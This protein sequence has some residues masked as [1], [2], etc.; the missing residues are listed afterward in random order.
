MNHRLAF[1]LALAFSSSGALLGCAA[2]QDDSQ[3]SGGAGASGGGGGAST[4]VGPSTGGGSG[5]GGAGGV[6]GAGGS[7]GGLSG[8]VELCVLN[9]GEPYGTCEQPEELDFGVVSSG[10][11]EKRLFRVDNQTY[12]DLL[13]KSTSIASNAFAVEAVRFEEDPGSPGSYLRVQEALPI[14]RTSDKS[15]WFEVTYT[16]LGNAGPLPSIDVVVK[17]NLGADPIADISVPVVGEESGC[18]VGTGAC[19]ADPANGCETNTQTSNDHCGGCNIP[20]DPVNGSGQCVNGQCELADCDAYF[21]SCD[22]NPANGCET[23]LLSDVNNCGGCGLSC[24]KANTDSFCNGGNC[25]IIGCQNNHADCNLSAADGCE[26]NLANDMSHCGGCNLAC[27]LPNAAESC[28]PSA[29]T[30][31]GVCQLGA[32]NTGFANCNLNPADGCEINTTNDVNNCGQCFQGCNFANASA[33]C[34]NSGCQMGACNANHADCDNSPL[35]GCEVNL[36]TNTNNCGACDNNCVNVIPNSVVSCSAFTCLSSGCN[37]NYWDLSPTA[38]GCEYFCVQQP[39]A[40]LPDDG[41]VDSNCDGIDGDADAAVFVATGGSDSN[42]GTRAA[43]MLTINGAIARAQSTSKT[44]IYVSNGIYTGRVTLASGISIYGGYSASNNWARSAAFQATIRSNTVSGGRMSAVEGTDI[45]AATTLDR[46]TIE[47]TSTAQ[48]GVSN[49]GL[50]C[51]NCDAL[52]LKNNTI[53]AGSAGGGTAGIGGTTGAS[54]FTGS[55]GGAGSCDSNNTG[56]PGGSGGSSTC[57]RPGGAGGKGGNSP[58]SNAGSPGGTGAVGTSGGNGGNGGNPGQ[59]G[60]N[61]SDGTNGG[62][63]AVGSAGIGGFVSLGYWVSNAGGAGG[64]GSAG[65]AGGG[66]GGGGSQ[67]CTLCNDGYGNGGGGGGSAGCGGTGGTGGTG[68]GGSFGLFLLNSNGITLVNNV[69]SAG[70]GGAGGA[71]GAGASGGTGANGASGGTT[72][73][74]EVGRG[75]NGGKGGNG[76]TGGGGGG[77]AGGPSYA[78][79]RS[80]TTLSTVGNSLSFGSGGA[81]G[82]GGSPNG[83]TG[84]T[85]VAAQ[86]N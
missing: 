12:E 17:M 71:G 75:G 30:G 35:T 43:P 47:T 77:G 8:L 32:C 79:Y 2:G 49:Y 20:C 68:G 60:A 58:G 26:T 54:G 44:Q 15:L 74:G 63:G 39:G 5:E 28:V 64:T 52:T 53:S 70:N 48:A 55:P 11:T 62:L 24:M 1:S 61:G 81:G 7:G 6:G 78:I 27:D 72:C 66:G 83:G 56:A 57:G 69:I 4:T 46:L 40:D 23:P 31:L 19:D 82:L 9:Q 76:G 14:T 16:A 42:P 80:G 84:S 59:P 36:Q 45:L 29:V 22:M 37:T 50:Y 33:S 38:P 73:T 51:N 85:G 18:P 34:V 41:F 25:N 13:F 3:G 86:I 67:S 10:T 21:A 65:N